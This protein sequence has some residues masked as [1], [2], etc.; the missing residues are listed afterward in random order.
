[1]NSCL[2]QKLDQLLEV[3]MNVACISS[4]CFHFRA[5]CGHPGRVLPPG[6]AGILGN[7]LC[8]C[9]DWNI[10]HSS[11]QS[12]WQVGKDDISRPTAKR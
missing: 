3:T 4:H 9:L 11:F 5:A 12:L 1:M 10:T 8:C 2:G 6:T 7:T